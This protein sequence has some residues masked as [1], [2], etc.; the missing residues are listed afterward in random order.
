MDGWMEAKIE[1]EI[2]IVIERG[3]SIVRSFNRWKGRTYILRFLASGV[4]A[5]TFPL[6][7]GG[8]MECCAVSSRSSLRFQSAL[9]EVGRW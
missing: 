7:V 4:N 5:K 9:T 3:R 8:E 2:E 6:Q 1:I